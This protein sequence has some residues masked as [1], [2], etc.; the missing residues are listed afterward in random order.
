MTNGVSDAACKVTAPLFHADGKTPLRSDEHPL[1]LALGGASSTMEIAAASAN[2]SRRFI[3]LSAA[4]LSTAD[5]KTAGA[6]SVV[7]DTTEQHRLTSA[8]EE[9]NAK[10][11][12]TQRANADLVQRLR[13]AIDDLSTPVL[14]VWDD[15]L[16]LPIV[17]VVDSRRAGQIMERLLEETVKREP[18]Y[19]IIDVTG[20]EIID[21][22]TAEHFMKLARAVELVGARCLLTGI[23]PAVGQTLVELGLDLGA[24]RTLRN[25]KHALRETVRKVGRQGNGASARRTNGAANGR[26]DGR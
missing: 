9:R 22:K 8:I 6:V 13:L 12:E 2:G 21:S 3:S 11:E 25:L 1:A 14:E 4:P 23:R 17:G 24:A 15:V 18:R 7:R 19:V 26:H 10:L 5:G 16:A 20:V